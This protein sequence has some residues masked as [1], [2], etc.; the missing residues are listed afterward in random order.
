MIEVVDD[1]VL[2]YVVI[3]DVEVDRVF[4]VG[5]CGV[6]CM[7]M[8]CI[9]VEFGVFIGIWFDDD[10]LLLLIFLYWLVIDS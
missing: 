6:L 3:G 1:V 5:L 7:L 9:M 2:V 4:E 10:D 8:E